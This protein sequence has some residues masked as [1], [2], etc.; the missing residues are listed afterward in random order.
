ME[1]FTEIY[2]CRLNVV[3]DKNVVW[4]AN[5]VCN[6]LSFNFRREQIKGC[7]R[8]ILLVCFVCLKGSTCETKKKFLFHFESS[9]RS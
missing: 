3:W 1:I 4:D 6:N 9:F 8:Y 2:Y 5:V 7:V